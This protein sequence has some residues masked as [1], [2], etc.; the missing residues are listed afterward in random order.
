[1]HPDAPSIGPDARDARGA[2]RSASGRHAA[3]HLAWQVRRWWRKGDLAGRP[4]VALVV[5]VAVFLLTCIYRFNALGGSLG[6][7]DGDHFI[8]YLGARAV[9]LGE[10]P[11]RDFADAG[12]QGA[13]PALTYELPALA[14]QLGRGTLLDEAVFVVLALALAFA[15][16]ASTAQRLS[17]PLS[18]LIVAAATLS[19]SAKLYGYSKVLVFAVAAALFLAYARRPTRTRAMQLAAWSAV[20]FLFRHDF[21]AYLMPPVAVLMLL[22]TDVRREALD[23]LVVFA[24]TLAVLLAGP[25]YSIHRL[26]GIGSYLETARALVAGEAN[27]TTFRWPRIGAWQGDLWAFFA[28]ENNAIAWLYYLSVA[29]PLVALLTLLRSPR[30]SN[31]DARQTRAVI[32]SL[33]VLALILDRA[34]LRN[35]LGAR[36][37][38]LGA[39]VAIL[40]AW[41]LS[42]VSPRPRW[43][44]SLA[45][46][47]A[48]LVLVP[49]LLA[50]STT[51]SVRS[52]LDTTGLSDSLQKIRRRLATVAAE[53][54]AIPPR[55]D[56]PPEAEPNVSDYIRTCTATTD[57]VLVIAD[58]PGIL[59]M[60]GRSFAGGHP[61]FR[62]GFHRLEKD[63]RLTLERLRGQSVPVVVLEDEDA[64]SSHFAGEFA[65]VHEHVVGEYERA[66]SLPAPGRPPVQVYTR[67]GLAATRAYGQTGLPCFRRE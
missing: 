13:W 25:L 45:S 67:R 58:A 22:A 63:Q 49:T 39:P 6:G 66:G 34:F 20:A 11:L 9:A 40:A 10:R 41:L 26:M 43:R 12:L 31:L 56:A 29:I 37:G 21:L 52:E 33:A 62:P 60:A 35:N 7:F 38:D 23:R 24:A 36:F 19:A 30:T 2:E 44:R 16:L 15:L 59:A 65:L 55:P 5:P 64:Y 46:A 27:R 32:A 54:S 1:M 51:G 61:T 4:I 28:D 42:G 8:Y 47:L 57:R 17:G 14:Q 53:L 48:L 50:L 3:R 18:A